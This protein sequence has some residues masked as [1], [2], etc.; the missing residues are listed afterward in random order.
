MA[1]DNVTFF[2]KIWRLNMAKCDFSPSKYGD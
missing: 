1:G 2:L